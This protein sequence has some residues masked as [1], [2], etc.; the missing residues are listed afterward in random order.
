[1][2]A[3]ADPWLPTVFW[4]IFDRD[5]SWQQANI[6]HAVLS[7]CL[8][9]RFEASYRETCWHIECKRKWIVD[10]QLG[11]QGIISLT[12]QSDSTVASILTDF[13]FI[14]NESHGECVCFFVQK[15]TNPCLLVDLFVWNDNNKAARKKSKNFIRVIHS[16]GCVCVSGNKIAFSILCSTNLQ[17]RNFCIILFEMNLCAY[18][19]RWKCYR[20]FSDTFNEFYVCNIHNNLSTWI[21]RARAVCTHVSSLFPLGSMHSTATFCLQIFSLCWLYP[22]TF[23]WSFAWKVVSVQFVGFVKIRHWMHSFI[24]IGR[25]FLNWNVALS[26]GNHQLWKSIVSILF[27]HLLI[28]SNQRQKKNRM[29]IDR[30]GC[31]WKVFFVDTSK[32]GNIVTLR[33]G[34]IR[35]YDPKTTKC[36][37]DNFQ[38]S[39]HKQNCGILEL[40]SNGMCFHGIN[41]ATSCTAF[42]F[43]VKCCSKIHKM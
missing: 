41:Y 33:V 28:K 24:F 23:A 5:I 20:N 40:T 31:C 10:M 13:I 43:I 9:I 17:I 21:Q 3:N 39:R 16:G 38:G 2:H 11:F 14:S 1:M 8:C 7:K 32:Y 22:F 30:Y 19:L 35:L 18:E 36:A 6:K 26:N 27:W 42:S 12:H 34:G 15:I 4:F 25:K 37:C 29:Q